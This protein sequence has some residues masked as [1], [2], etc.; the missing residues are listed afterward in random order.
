MAKLSP[1][2]KLEEKV[3][4]AIT[5]RNL[6][7]LGDRIVVAVS[8]GPDSVAL[9]AC[10]VALAPRWKWTISIGHVNHG[11]R[12]MESE[13]DAA[14]VEQLGIALNVPVYIRK[15]RLCKEEVRSSR[16][17]L[18]E[19]AREVRYQAME[20]IVQESGS[21]KIATGH[22]ADDQAETVLMWMLRGSG[23]GGLSGIP[24]KRG[25]RIVRPILDFPRNEIVK[26]LDQRE[27]TYRVDS[28]NNQAAYLRNR[29]RNN[30]MPQL[31]DYAPGLVSV[32][33]RQAEI[34]RED[35]SY[36]EQVAAEALHE[37]M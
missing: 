3:H 17:S 12:G 25:E 34:I 7:C 11:L 6:F 20:D 30:L 31:Q 10:L 23:T 19:H 29:I 26:Y 5:A 4:Q 14:F 28:S 8:G 27:L 2:L 16:Q 21:T 37:N 24:P 36:L 32:L 33:S 22:T 15:P 1:L 35:H 18:Q 13:E 9:L